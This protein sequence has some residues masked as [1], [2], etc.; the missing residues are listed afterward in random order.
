MSHISKN[1]PN[2]KKHYFQN[3]LQISNNVPN[4]ENVPKF[5][6]LICVQTWSFWQTNFVKFWQF[7]H[8]LI[9]DNFNIFC[10]HFL[11][12]FDNFDNSLLFR[13]F[14]KKLTMFFKSVKVWMRESVWKSKRVNS[15]I[16]FCTDLRAVG[17]KVALHTPDHPPLRKPLHFFCP[18]NLFLWLNLI[19]TSGAVL[20]LH[21]GWYYSNSYSYIFIFS[22]IFS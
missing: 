12:I 7:L 3:R 10:W 5:K 2:L 21:L 20:H 17:A 6:T 14:L 9:F 13:H 18:F 19:L 15:E 1:V 8:F 4:F 16:D 22:L 11:H